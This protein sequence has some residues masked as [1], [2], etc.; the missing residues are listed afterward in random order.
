MARA[1]LKKSGQW[2]YANYCTWPE[3]ERWELIDGEAYDMSPAPSMMHQSVV[4]ELG[5]IL[6]DFFRDRRCRVLAVPVDVLLPRSDEADEAVNTVVQPDLL[7][8]CD[9]EKITERFI[10][11]APDLVVEVLSPTTAK[12][13]E[14]IKR[15]RYEQAGVA[16]YWLV[17]PVDHTVLRYVLKEGRYGRPDVF[18]E[19]D[20]MASS[21]FP[22]LLVIWDE[23]FGVTPS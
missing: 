21:R 20:T 17:H 8:V 4:M 3:E 15:D 1:A 16:E 7:V 23:V 18:G 14:G 22:D 9:S 12:K 10:R 5:Y 11:G 19:G 2:T 6:R 13:D